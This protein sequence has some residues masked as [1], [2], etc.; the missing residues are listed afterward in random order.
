MTDGFFTI[1]GT[2][3]KAQS[4]KQGFESLA[5]EDSGRV[6]NGTMVIEWVLSKIRKLEIVMPPMTAAEASQLLSLVQGQTYSMTYHDALANADK[7]K[8]FYTSNSAADCYSGVIRNGLYQNV[9][10]NAV[11]IGGE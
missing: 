10:F 11:E 4:L 8:T 5:S 9:S 6:D 1:G 2:T 7:T 3:F